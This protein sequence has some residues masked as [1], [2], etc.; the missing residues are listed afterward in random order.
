MIGYKATYNGKCKNKTYKLGKTYTL[1]GKLK[2]CEKGFHFC[3]D[4]IDV[5]EYYP[6]NKNIKVFKVEAVG[7]VET[8]ND[9][10]VTDKIKILEEVNLSNMILEKHDY[11]KFFDDKGNYIKFETSDGYWI[12]REYDERNNLIKFENS[13]G[14]LY[15][16]EHDEN[17][18][19]IKTEHSKVAAKEHRHDRL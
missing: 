12:K 10:S 4:L 16:Y 11:K 2:M 1:R 8:E 19:L 17:N 6:P 18:R 9:K 7:N 5:F 13:E 15:K 3:K 14:A